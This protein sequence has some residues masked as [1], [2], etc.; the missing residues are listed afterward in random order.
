MRRA[1]YAARMPARERRLRLAL[2]WAA[3]LPFT[4]DVAM[5]GS[6]EH[7]DRPLSDP[8]PGGA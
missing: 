8:G 7:P 6:A 5:L 3:G 1:Y 4:R 2:D